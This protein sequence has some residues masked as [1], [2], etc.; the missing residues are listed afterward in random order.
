MKSSENGRYGESIAAEF[1]EANG[2]TILENGEFIW[3]DF[4]G[5]IINLQK[6]QDR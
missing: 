3:K 2:Y 1:Y 4:D 5:N 6:K